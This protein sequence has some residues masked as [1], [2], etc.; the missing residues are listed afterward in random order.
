MN[1]N[2][3]SS[4]YTSLYVKDDGAYIPDTSSSI[5]NKQVIITHLFRG[6]KTIHRGY[7][8]CNNEYP[9]YVLIVAPRCVL[10]LYI[11]MDKIISME[12]Q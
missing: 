7:I 3:I 2:F 12:I 4:A 10:G 1:P 6:K 11:H 9:S 8:S 5:K